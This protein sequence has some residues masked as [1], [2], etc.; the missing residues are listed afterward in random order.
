MIGISEDEGIQV[1]TPQKNIEGDESLF[2]CDVLDQVTSSG[3]SKIR[4]D[5]FNVTQ[6]DASA[7][8]GLLLFKNMTQAE[9]IEMV[10][11]EKILSALL[12]TIRIC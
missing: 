4:L 1:I 11:M 9:D 7:L 12:S 2:F 3:N 10:K 8:C 5:F 6:I